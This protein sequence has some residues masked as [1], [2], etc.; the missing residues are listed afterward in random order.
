MDDFCVYSDRMLHVEKLN[1]VFQRMD[2]D[3]G[4]LNPS[5]CK[6]ARARVILLG[7]EISENGISPDPSKVECLLAMEIPTNVKMLI[8]FVQKLRY[9]SRSFCMLAEHVHPLQKA[10]Q[11]DPFIWT[12]EEQN[13]FENVKD[14]LCTLPIMMPP[15]WNQLF[16]LSLSVGTHAVGAVLMQKGEK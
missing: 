14:L 5:K 7:H 10:T 11:R 15:S 16:Y 1:E 3:G 9:L 13:A 2:D 8:S 4:Q 6:I 12:Q